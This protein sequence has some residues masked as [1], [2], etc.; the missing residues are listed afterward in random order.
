MENLEQSSSKYEQ[1]F[2][3][4]ESRVKELR[5]ALIEQENEIHKGKP[6]S[7]SVSEWD[8]LLNRRKK[9]QNDLREMIVALGSTP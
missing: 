7:M 2:I 4:S 8:N 3:D 5:E 9:I 6:E 1:L